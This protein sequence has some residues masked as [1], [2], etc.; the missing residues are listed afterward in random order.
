MGLFKK[1]PLRNLL[2]DSDY[3]LRCYPDVRRW[4][5]GA[6]NH[7]RLFG[8]RERRNPHPL[9]DTRFYLDQNPSLERAQGNPLKHFLKQGCKAMRSPHPCIDLI[10][11]TRFLN[12]RVNAA[13][14]PFLYYL[15]HGG[16]EGLLTEEHLAQVRA[17]TQATLLSETDGA[18][19]EARIAVALH[20]YY[21]QLWESIKAHLRNI[22]E[23]FDLHITFPRFM[24]HPVFLDILSEYPRANLVPTDNHGR[25][26]LPFLR[27]YLGG[28]FD[29]YDYVCK[30]HT[31]R[32]P[33]RTDGSAWRTELYDSLLGSPLSVA[34]IIDHFDQ[35]GNVGLI[36]TESHLHGASSDCFWSANV[37]WIS[38]L[39]PRLQP[40]PSTTTWRFL[41]GSM[42]W[43]RPK[44]LAAMRMM[45]VREEDFEQELGQYDGTLAHAVERLFLVLV[46]TSGYRTATERDALGERA[47]VGAITATVP[48]KADVASVRDAIR[49]VFDARYYLDTY[50]D[51]RESG[52]DPLIHYLAN[53]AAEGRNPAPDFN[54][55]YYVYHHPELLA[56]GI[57][58]LYH[59]VVAGR[60]SLADTAGDYRKRQ[61]E[62]SR[63]EK[64]TGNPSPWERFERRS[65]S[66]LT[67]RFLAAVTPHAPSLVVAFSHDNYTKCVGG[68][69]LCVGLQQR[70]LR[71]SGKAYLVVYPAI[72]S[73]LLC[74]DALAGEQV[75]GVV[76]DG[77]DLGYCSGDDLMTALE[78]TRAIREPLSASVVIHALH[79]HAVAFVENVLD[80]LNKRDVFFFVHDFNA[81]C[82]STHLMR[83]G[84]IFCGGP[85]TTSSACGV[86]LHGDDRAKHVARIREFF[87]SHD[88]TVIAPSGYAL[89]LWRSTSGLPCAK[90]L[91][92]SH[93]DFRAT[94]V[95]T[96]T[97][98]GRLRVAF[99]GQPIYIKG[100]DAFSA[101]AKA[102]EGDRRYAFYAFSAYKPGH[103]NI[104]WKPV[105]VNIDT[106]DAMSR[107]LVR[108]KIDVAVLWS[109]CPE[110]FSFTAYEAR[111]AGTFIITTAESGN[112][113]DM[114]REYRQG[115][116]M[117]SDAELTAAFADGSV[118]D[119]FYGAVGTGI[120]TGSLDYSVGIETEIR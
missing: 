114:V 15:E 7:F 63:V 78:N 91:V 31:K 68:V 57:N 98:G 54:T 59:W 120:S 50:P 36:G 26:I 96:R 66:W 113:A 21:P 67:K 42:F 40:L 24:F 3:Y 115:L 111:A 97:A 47:T 87:S 70:S 65:A 109:L 101:L 69:Q 32:S 28:T 1:N 38:R 8:W 106:I 2:F 9:F 72:R 17:L 112:I 93:A 89:N 92:R 55:N 105:S 51:V 16:P 99:V 11:L 85:P 110:T 56:S 58:P 117:S 14:L 5:F 52:V 37:A 75:L 22:S 33:H 61:L 29:R 35:H 44:A 95:R 71:A 43:F 41:A 84:I 4:R 12:D 27:E 102:F 64:A 100:W 62:S 118:I 48:A 90:A 94:G 79:G 107:A 108:E 88:V 73:D 19:P 6:K 74:D 39:A 30:I 76:L 34:K 53:G 86:C 83:N 13:A 23:P 46:E 116:V 103:S 49:D 45:A 18:S 80:L 82:P 20:L 77:V 60:V 119:A 104:E 81:V 10:H 25:D